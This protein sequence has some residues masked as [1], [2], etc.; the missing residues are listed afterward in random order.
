MSA[1]KVDVDSRMFG[2]T[3]NDVV[4]DER[5]VRPSGDDL[6]FFQSWSISANFPILLVG[7]PSLSFCFRFGWVVDRLARNGPFPT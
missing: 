5:P 1:G 3:A 6:S 4:G 2:P 7:W